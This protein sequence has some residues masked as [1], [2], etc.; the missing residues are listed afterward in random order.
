LKEVEDHQWMSRLLSHSSPKLCGTDLQFWPVNSSLISPIT[1]C[2]CKS[3]AEADPPVLLAP[4]AHAQS[5]LPLTVVTTTHTLRHC[6]R[7]QY[8]YLTSNRRRQSRQ[9]N[10]Y[11]PQ[12]KY[13]KHNTHNSG[14]WSKARGWRTSLDHTGSQILVYMLLWRLKQIL[15]TIIAQVDLQKQ[16]SFPTICNILI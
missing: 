2:I 8:N 13:D 9:S 11:T 3:Q 15:N 16:P 7:A 6:P 4:Y 5:F 1:Y 14:L 10:L 12:Y